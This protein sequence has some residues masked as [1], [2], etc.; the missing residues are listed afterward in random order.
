MSERCL[1]VAASGG[2]LRI[3]I[4]MQANANISYS[5][6][7]KRKLVDV[8]GVSRIIC[9]APHSVSINQTAS[10]TLDF[11]SLRDVP[12]P[13]LSTSLF[14]LY[15]RWWQIVWLELTIR[16]RCAATDQSRVRIYSQFTFFQNYKTQKSKN[17]KSLSR[18]VD[19]NVGFVNYHE[20]VDTFLCFLFYFYF[21]ILLFY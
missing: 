15:G 9:A 10:V 3:A 16:L 5:P 1:A 18:I 8:N 11:I 20:T 2:A 19:Q 17:I 13:L 14:A 6:S 12:L 4:S 7:K 21:W